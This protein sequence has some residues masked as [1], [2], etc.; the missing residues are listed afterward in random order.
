MLTE[1]NTKRNP[2]FPLFLPPF[3]GINYKIAVRAWGVHAVL[4]SAP[5]SEHANADTA[6]TFLPDREGEY[7][8]RSTYASLGMLQWTHFSV[9][10]IEPITRK[11][12]Q[13]YIWKLRPPTTLKGKGTAVK[14]WQEGNILHLCATLS[15][16]KLQDV[17]HLFATLPPP[18]LLRWFLTHGKHM[19]DQGSCSHFQ[20]ALVE[21]PLHM[22]TL[23]VSLPVHHR[24]YAVSCD[25]E[26][27]EPPGVRTWWDKASSWDQFFRREPLQSSETL[28][29]PISWP[30]WLDFWVCHCEFNVPQYTLISG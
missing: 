15:T 7:A 3:Q 4:I 5:R 11:I 21:E 23:C 26:V 12:Q 20:P 30:A 9:L 29:T 18:T 8:K 10:F 28:H 25:T 24:S 14:C 22:L 1:A 17:L 2:S 16:P 13:N 27:I 6:V 19:H